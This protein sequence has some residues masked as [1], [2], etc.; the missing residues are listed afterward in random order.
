MSAKGRSN[1]PVYT[2]TQ[3]KLIPYPGDHSR[4]FNLTKRPCIDRFLKNKTKRYA[5]NNNTA[6]FHPLIDIYNFWKYPI[7]LVARSAVIRKP[8]MWLAIH[9][10]G[11][12]RF[13]VHRASALVIRK[14]FL[15]F[16]VVLFGSDR[17]FEIFLGDGVPV[18]YAC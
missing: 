5:A 2:Q 15:N 6:P 7:H 9:T 14:E 17:E 16:P 12:F 1:A 10:T 11:V 13:L 4:H 8:G 3:K 18:L